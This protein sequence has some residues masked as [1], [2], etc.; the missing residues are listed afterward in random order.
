MGSDF[1]NS[2]SPNYSS[3]F[4]K[5]EFFQGA[6]F[7][8]WGTSFIAG[9]FSIFYYLLFGLVF[10]YGLDKDGHGR[11]R[12]R[13][14]YVLL[15]IFILIGFFV[16][17]ISQVRS[18]LLKTLL[19]ILLGF[20]SGFLKT[21]FLIRRLLLVFVS[22][23]IVFASSFVFIRTLP[24]LDA[25]FDL[26]H[27]IGRF[28]ALSDTE[29]VAGARFGPDEVF[30]I[31]TEGVEYP[32]GFGLGMTTNF[33]PDF[34]AARET[35]KLDIDLSRF[36]SGDNLIV[37]F[38]LELG[39]GALFILFSYVSFPY[40]LFSL[41]IEALKSRTRSEYFIIAIAFV[42]AFVIVLGNWGAAS[43]VYNPESFFFMFWVGLGFNVFFHGARRTVEENVNLGKI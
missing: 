8:P 34:Q 16:L 37:F 12:A 6:V 20:S 23:A 15:M 36:W 42:Q 9:G 17:F 4:K 27:A 30:K 28:S 18:A 26:D 43:I 40:Y 11:I 32:L 2:L 35:R 10:I 22:I 19:V 41:S 33:L 38:F 39:L 13:F 31:I 7:R 24:F 21:K 14:E 5:Y 3:L 1:L 29:E 25:A